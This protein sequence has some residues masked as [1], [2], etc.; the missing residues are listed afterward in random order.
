[1]NFVVE[2]IRLITVYFFWDK[3]TFKRTMVHSN[4][5]YPVI[6]TSTSSPIPGMYDKSLWDDIFYIFLMTSDDTELFSILNLIHSHFGFKCFFLQKSIFRF[7]RSIN[8]N[9]EYAVTN[10]CTFS[11]CSF[12]F[13]PKSILKDEIKNLIIK[14]I[15]S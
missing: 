13:F 12:S 9:F 2:N 8:N 11:L 5:S 15:H 6:P 10:L 14:G 4:M 3:A 7:L 1:M